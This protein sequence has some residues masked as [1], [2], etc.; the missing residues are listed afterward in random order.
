MNKEISLYFH[1]PFCAKKCKYCAFC[2]YENVA[3]GKKQEYFE[4]IC[5]QLDFFEEKNIKSVY[6]GGG[7]P[8]MLK[9]ERLEALIRKIKDKF[10]LGGDVEFTVEVNPKTVDF[11]SLSRLLDAGANRLSVG[12]QSADDGVLKNLGRI[13]DFS[14]A[15]KC[16]SD[17]RK[18]GFTN[19]SAD[20]MFAL[21]Y[22][23]EISFE[24][25]LK[26]IIGLGVNHISAYSLQLEEGTRLFEEKELLKFPSEDEEEA[27]YD[28]LC[29]VMR[30]NGFSHYEVSSFAKDGKFS[31]HN[32]GY[33][34]GR[35]YF[36]FGAAAHSYYRNKRFSN[37]CALDEYIEKSKISLFAPTDFEDVNELTLEEKEEER[38]MLSLRTSSGVHLDGDRLLKAENI[39]KLGFGKVENGV[40]IL[41]DK[42]FRVSNEIIAEIITA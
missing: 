41:N 25:N 39:A 37:T 10:S 20:V 7:T 19:I 38:I 31:I 40:F 28:T 27:Q 35:E 1:I 8:P 29:R 17:A 34:S 33:W 2:S 26:R 5:R 23:S 22:P 12:V 18:A 42:G 4:A 24:E 16:I 36:G 21:P 9:T 6:I 13:H 14:D 11:T 30:E 15:E 3:D 32:G